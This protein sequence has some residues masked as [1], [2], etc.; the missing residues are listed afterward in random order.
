[1]EPQPELQPQPELLPEIQFGTPVEIATSPVF[2]PEKI[3]PAAP[4]FSEILVESQVQIPGHVDLPADT[5]FPPF[6]ITPIRVPTRVAGT[7]ASPLLTQVQGGALGSPQ[8][9][10]RLSSNP[11]LALQ[12]QLASSAG[13]C[14]PRKCQDDEN[15]PRVEC[16][17]G[18]YK[19]GH[20]DTDFVP[21]IEIDCVTGKEKGKGNGSNPKRNFRRSGSNG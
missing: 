8:L 14:K 9:H 11:A 16:F 4:I 12:P 20:I 10:P 18:L 2:L 13:E 3:A 5:F 1:V 7:V 19:E 6:V 21:W 15:D 17:K